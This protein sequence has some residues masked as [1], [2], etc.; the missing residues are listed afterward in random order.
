M[1]GGA[2]CDVQL[3]ELMQAQGLDVFEGYGTSEMGVVAWTERGNW[4]PNKLKIVDDVEL[5][6]GPDGELLAKTPCMMLGYY[7]ESELTR[8]AFTEDGFYRTGDF[9]ELTDDGYFRYVGR[10]RDVF[11]TPEGANIHP[12]RI[13]DMLDALEWV[14]QVVLI[15]DG[16]PYLSALI[17]VEEG[18]SS[19]EDGYLEAAANPRL[20]E[21]ARSAIEELNRKLESIEKVR[22]VA[23]F[24]RPMGPE[25][26]SYTRTGKVSRK[27]KAVAKSFASRIEQLYRDDASGLPQ[28][29]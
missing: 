29:S 27:R 12:T 15:G 14:S 3:F 19:A 24:A 13:E 4:Q 21:R 1:T 2:R 8:A 9:C 11:N 20:Y 6:Q 18:E 16:R 10:K 28:I 7:G 22:R 25:L 23:L 17:V 26:Y 5:K